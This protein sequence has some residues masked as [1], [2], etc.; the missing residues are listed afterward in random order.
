MKNTI[1]NFETMYGNEEY[2]VHSIFPKLQIFQL[3]GP[4]N[5]RTWQETHKIFRSKVGL[6]KLLKLSLQIAYYKLSK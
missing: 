3:Q 1:I 2:I 6:F 5:V 4:Y